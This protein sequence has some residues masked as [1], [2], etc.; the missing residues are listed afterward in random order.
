MGGSWERTIGVTRKILDAMLLE[1]RNAKLTHEILVTLMAEVTAIVNARPL[2]AVSTDPEN[3]AILTPAMLLTQ[4]VATP[5]V[6]PGQ[7]ESRDLFRA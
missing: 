5:P 7:F 3:P 2:T 4:K 1:H 6:P